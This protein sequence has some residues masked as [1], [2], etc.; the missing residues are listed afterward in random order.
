MKILHRIANALPGELLSRL[1]RY[2]PEGSSELLFPLPLRNEL[3]LRKVLRRGD[4]VVF[5]SSYPRSGNTW[6]RKLLADLMLQKNGRQTDTTLPI[7]HDKLIPDRDFNAVAE[8]ERLPHAPGLTVK[9]HDRI[10]TIQKLYPASRRGEVRHIY[11]YRNPADA[12]VSHYHFHLRYEHLA[13]KLGN[14]GVDAFCL[15]QFDSWKE[16]VESY[17]EAFEGGEEAIF[18]LSYEQLSE[19]AVPL[20]LELCEWL[21]FP[22]EPGQAERAVEHH[23]FKK[24][25]QK[26]AVDPVNEEELFFRKG[27]VGG[28]RE[29]LQTSTL[30]ELDRRSEALLRRG[31]ACLG[32]RIS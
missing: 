24:L 23:R 5:V 12:L 13:D 30:E 18:I 28:G 6:L 29:E 10:E 1:D 26:E 3:F 8:A 20:L 25:Q 16:H 31:D 14:T 11:I 32:S 27:K 17:L 15:E 2:L 9:T 4:G 22:V 19:N 21:D 7:H